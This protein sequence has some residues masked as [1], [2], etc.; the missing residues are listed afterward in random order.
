MHAEIEQLRQKLKEKENYIV[1][2][3]TQ[4]LKEV[5][6][7]PNGKLASMKIDLRLSEEKHARLMEAQKRML[8]VNQNLED[9]LLKLVDK[10]E[11]EK[12]AFI[13][14]IA[15]LSHRLADANLTIHSLSQDNVII[16]YYFNF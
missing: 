5:D 14:D 11:T 9:K 7:F 15:T 8:K 12:S 6:K 2:I 3:E 16:F 13:K 1:K 4:Y 10:C